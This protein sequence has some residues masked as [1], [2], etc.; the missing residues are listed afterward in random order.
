MDLAEAESIA[1]A[2]RPSP[3]R[4]GG[5]VANVDQPRDQVTEWEERVAAQF[6]GLKAWAKSCGCLLKTENLPKRAFGPSGREH[7]VFHDVVQ[8]RFWKATFPNQAGCGPF[9]FFT[10]AGYL[11]RLRLTNRIFCDD[12]R[13]EGVWVRKLGVSLVTSQSYIQ[14]HT[15]RFIPTEAE[16]SSFLEQLGFH[17]EDTSAAWEREDGVVLGDTHDRNFIRAPDGLLYAIDV[18]A[19]M[20]SGFDWEAVRQWSGS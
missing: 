1:I 12:V 2:N 6:A 10:P 8:S 20:K 15:E 11:R 17:W 4:P 3:G 7:E 13:F 19:R 16:I 14:P 9:G 18:Q 5:R